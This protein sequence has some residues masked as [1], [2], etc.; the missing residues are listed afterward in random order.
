LFIK[1]ISENTEKSPT[2]KNG[3]NSGKLFSKDLRYKF[4]CLK[5]SLETY[6]PHLVILQ[7][8]K[9]VSKILSRFYL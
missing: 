3:E 1:F 9:N 2:S 6:H 4:A 5:N 8:V 7:Y